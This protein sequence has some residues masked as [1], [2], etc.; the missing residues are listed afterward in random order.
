RFVRRL[1][2]PKESSYIL[3]QRKGVFLV[4]TSMRA[5]RT[6][7]IEVICTVATSWVPT[8]FYAKQPGENPMNTFKLICGV[9]ALTLLTDAALAAP[10]AQAPAQVSQKS[11]AARTSSSAGTGKHR[12]T[13]L[14]DAQMDK[15]TAGFDLSAVG[16][17]LSDIAA[18]VPVSPHSGTAELSM[19]KAA[20][21]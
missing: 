21:Q 15:V 17:A 4:E 6:D 12:P 19:R 11:E 20:G 13:A 8:R 5:S 16:A 1:P 9:A 18:S 10:D 7:P 14:A 2:A 3:E